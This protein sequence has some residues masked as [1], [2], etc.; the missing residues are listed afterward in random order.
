VDLDLEPD[1]FGEYGLRDAFGV[2]RG[3]GCQNV[4]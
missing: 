2:V 4:A 1:A 3:L